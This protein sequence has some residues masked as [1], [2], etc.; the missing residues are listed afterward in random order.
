M[1]EDPGMVVIERSPG[2]E[3]RIGPYTLRVVAVDPDGVVIALHDPDEDGDPPGP[4]LAAPD[5][6]P[7][8]E[9]LPA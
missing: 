8:A 6:L 9:C 5:E 7:T 4:A 3:V 1:E 2:Q